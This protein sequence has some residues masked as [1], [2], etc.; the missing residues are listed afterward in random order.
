[1][2]E[3]PLQV[4]MSQSVAKLSSWLRL[5]LGYESSQA[6]PPTPYTLH[7]TPYTPHPSPYTLHPTPY[8]LHPAPYILHPTPYTLHPTLYTLHPTP[9]TLHRPGS[10]SSWATNPPRHSPSSLRTNGWLNYYSTRRTPS[11]L[12]NQSK[13][14]LVSCTR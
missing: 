11:L 10:G 7:P 6:P 14:L 13:L 1:M 12:E 8:T 9:Y 3:V 5:Q 4:I 2:S